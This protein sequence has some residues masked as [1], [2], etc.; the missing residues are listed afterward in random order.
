MIAP[1]TVSAMNCMIYIPFKCDFIK[2]N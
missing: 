1:R 2:S